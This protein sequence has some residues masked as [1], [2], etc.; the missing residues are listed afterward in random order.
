MSGAACA[1]IILN[2]CGLLGASALALN[3]AMD[4]TA[5]AFDDLDTAGLVTAEDRA[6]ILA[7]CGESAKLAGKMDSFRLQ[8]ITALREIAMRKEGQ[9]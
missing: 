8:W 5:E 3:E 7:L 6:K 2:N 4:G 1:V 9:S